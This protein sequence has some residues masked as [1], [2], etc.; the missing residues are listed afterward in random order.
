MELMGGPMRKTLIFL[1]MFCFLA[2]GCDKADRAGATMGATTSN[3]APADVDPSL[4]TVLV[5]AAHAVKEAQLYGKPYLLDAGP[6]ITLD[7]ARFV[8]QDPDHLGRTANTVQVLYDR[9]EFMTSWLIGKNKG[10]VQLNAQNLKMLSGPPFSGF[11]PGK[12]AFV[13]VG[14]RAAGRPA[15]DKDAFCPFWVGLVIFQ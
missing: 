11:E 3:S 14:Y 13:A 4:R 6:D 10:V 12:R 1:G 5:D 2:G 8:F 9:S 7:A 15:S